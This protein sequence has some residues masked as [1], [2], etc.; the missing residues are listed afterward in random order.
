MKTKL[1]SIKKNTILSLISL[2]QNYSSYQVIQR[3]KSPDYQVTNLRRPIFFTSRSV[4]HICHRR[5]C[6]IS[7]QKFQQRNFCFHLYLQTKLFLFYFKRHFIR[8]KLFLK[9][10]YY[11][12]GHAMT[13]KLHVTVYFPQVAH[14]IEQ[15]A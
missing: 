6:L 7:L 15:N 2:L 13:I 4:P 11:L 10:L 9:L 3:H 1:S 8:A 5:L 14:A 12:K